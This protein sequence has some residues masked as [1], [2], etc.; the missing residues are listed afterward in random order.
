MDI[1][2]LGAGCIQVTANKAKFVIDP[3]TK[4]IAK[5]KLDKEAVVLKTNMHSTLEDAGDR[6]VI[7][8]PG[9]YEINSMAIRG[10]QTPAYT[11]VHDEEADSNVV[12]TL[13]TTSLRLCAIGHP[14]LQLDEKVLEEIGNVDILVVPIGGGGFTLDAESATKMV[15]SI[16]PAVVIPVHYDMPDVKYEVPQSKLQLFLDEVGGEV[17]KE[18]TL[19]IKSAPVEETLQVYVLA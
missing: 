10:I 4:D 3:P 9:E 18:D 19:K 2:A 1:K 5:V 17:H 12:Y 16:D 6:F 13:R 8:L 11:Q 14:S 15:K 7:D